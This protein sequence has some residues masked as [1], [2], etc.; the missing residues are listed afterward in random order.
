QQ[1]GTQ[2]IWWRF[3]KDRRPAALPER[4]GVASEDILLL[5]R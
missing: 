5:Y 4:L 2:H 1:E 3:A